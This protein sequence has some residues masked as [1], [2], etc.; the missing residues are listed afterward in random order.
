VLPAQDKL[1]GSFHVGRKEVNN[2]RV[3][4][5]PQMS[6]LAERPQRL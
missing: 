4:M 5:W 1:R 6:L 2:P 3:A